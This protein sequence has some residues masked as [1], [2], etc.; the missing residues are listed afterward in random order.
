M[1]APVNGIGGGGARYAM[2]ETIISSAP[3]ILADFA[4][5]ALRWASPRLG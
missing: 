1:S 2:L 3:A 5:C 4:Y